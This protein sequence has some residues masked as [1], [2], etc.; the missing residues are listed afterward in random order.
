MVRLTF[1]WGIHTNRASRVREARICVGLFSS[2][3]GWA[4][5]WFLFCW[6]GIGILANLFR[7]LLDFSQF[8][9]ASNPF[10]MVCAGDEKIS[11][12]F[13][14]RIGFVDVRAACQCQIACFFLPGFGGTKVFGQMSAGTSGR[15]LPLWADFPFQMLN[16]VYVCFS[17]FQ[18]DS[19]CDAPDPQTG[20]RI[21]HFLERLGVQNPHFPSP[22]Q[23]LEKGV[24]GPK[25]P[26]FDVF[27][28]RKRG[29]FDRKLPCPE[30]GEM[31]VFARN[32]LFQEMGIRAPVWGRGNPETQS[33][34]INFMML[35]QGQM[36][37]TRTSW[38]GY[39]QN[40]AV[41]DRGFGKSSAPLLR[42]CHYARRPQNLLPEGISKGMIGKR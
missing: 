27:P 7:D 39:P 6:C 8:P 42:D 21:P 18:S 23:R 36:E 13:S 32:P 17:R 29:F 3:C 35:M 22:S 20:A 41:A 40:R 33:I 4:T 34:S 10:L 12:K 31:G 19:V 16:H 9:S 24:F 28:C 11:P 25:I 5:S 1:S 37:R 26:I 38:S 14:G 2:E 30:R 15:K